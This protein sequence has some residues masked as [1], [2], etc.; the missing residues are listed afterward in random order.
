MT[1]YPFG[2]INES[3]I[4]QG[5]ALNA[6]SGDKGQPVTLVT[7]SPGG[8]EVHTISRNIAADYT[9]NA[10]GKVYSPRWQVTNKVKLAVTGELPIGVLYYDVREL[11]VF[12]YPTSFDAIRRDEAEVVPS[13]ESVP[14]LQKGTVIIGPLS[15]AVTPAVNRF[16]LVS[17]TG[18]YASSSVAFAVTGTGGTSVQGPTFG[19]WLS[20]K[21]ADGYAIAQINCYA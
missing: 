4:L 20:I 1:L 13:G 14:I 11:T 16:I 3:D 10:A 2:N 9:A 19:R 15:A 18:N 21:D 8:A 17:G 6:A 12:G 7:G 5:Y